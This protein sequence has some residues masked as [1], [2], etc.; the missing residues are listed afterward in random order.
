VKQA[1]ENK[2]LMEVIEGDVNTADNIL[3]DASRARQLLL[4]LEGVARE[5]MDPTLDEHLQ[6]VAHDLQNIIDK[7]L[8][9]CLFLCF[10]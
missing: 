6:N 3:D 2:D 8:E 4:A 7:S 9:V 10:L 1:K 5:S